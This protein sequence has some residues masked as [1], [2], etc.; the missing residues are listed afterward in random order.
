[1][2]G[3]TQSINAAMFHVEPP[4]NSYVYGVVRTDSAA[5]HLKLALIPAGAHDFRFPRGPGVHPDG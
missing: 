4:P 3:H 1:M 5:F 2:R